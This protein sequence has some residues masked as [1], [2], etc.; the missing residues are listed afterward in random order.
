[1][2][3]CF[4]KRACAFLRL[5]YLSVRIFAVLF[6]NQVRLFMQLCFKNKAGAFCARLFYNLKIFRLQHSIIAVQPFVYY[7]GLF[8]CCVNKEEKGMAQHV[9]LQNG[10]LHI[11]RL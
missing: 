4:F 6:L 3:P 8:A 5:C 2:R 1:M 10:L 7:T 11:H 9:H